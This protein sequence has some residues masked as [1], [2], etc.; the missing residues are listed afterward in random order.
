MKPIRWIRSLAFAAILI[1]TSTGSRCSLPWQAVRLDDIT[2]VS[3]N[4]HNL[5]DDVD[6]GIEYPEFDPSTSNWNAGLYAKRLENTAFAIKTPYPER[7]SGPDILCLVE[8]ENSKVL[9][10]LA[11]GP[12]AHEGYQW[13]AIGGPESSPIKCGILSRIPMVEVRSHGVFDSWGLGGG[14]EI[15]E[16]SFE[17]ETS[18]LPKEETNSQLLTV[19]L[20]HWKSRKEGA[21]ATEE[22]R[23][24]SSRLVAARIVERMNEDPNR[25]IVV[26]GDFN[27]SPDEFSRIGSAYPTAFMP[28]SLGTKEEDSIPA[29]WLDGVLRVS[30]SQAE[31]IRTDGNIRVF[32]PWRGTEGYSYI[33]QGEKER[34]DGFLLGASFFDGKSYAFQ[35]FRVG[36]SPELLAEDGSPIGWN[37]TNGYSDHLPIAL[38]IAPILY[39][40]DDFMDK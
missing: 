35:D 16:V 17:L 2:I 19:F 39:S 34:L 20:C 10:D 24:A 23:R 6:N 26:C 38:T 22:A 1:L 8:I 5:F 36:T 31:C 7:D 27:E 15:L 18:K 30:N 4:A 32:S 37:G 40:R 9:K 11:S 13:S 21:A 14:R 29:S 25:L 3:F 33:F 12:L 28:S